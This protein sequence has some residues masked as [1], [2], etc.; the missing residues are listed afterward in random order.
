MIDPALPRFEA[1]WDTGTIAADL[2]A[3]LTLAPGWGVERVELDKIRH[4]MGER[5]IVQYRAIGTDGLARVEW[6]VTATAHADGKAA[7]VSVKSRRLGVHPPQGLGSA[8]GYHPALD[9]AFSAFPLD[10][11]L[12]AAVA[13]GTG[14]EFAGLGFEKMIPVR[15]RAGLGAT[16]RIPASRVPGGFLKLHPEGGAVASARRGS[17]VARVLPPS[18]GAAIP[19]LVPDL[20][21]ATITDQVAGESFDRCAD[22]EN[23]VLVAEALAALHQ[24]SAP[25]LPSCEKVPASRAERGAEWIRLVFPDATPALERAIDEAGRLTTGMALVHG[26]MKPDHLLIAG[27]AVTMV[28]LDSAGIGRPLSD[29]ASLVVR[30]AAP[31]IARSVLEAYAA[32]RPGMDWRGFDGELALAA[33]KFALYHAQHRRPGWEQAVLDTLEARLAFS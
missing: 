11:R 23:A 6:W 22:P 29:V 15:H 31:S 7:G 25:D 1:A 8:A 19:R 4:R 13:L 2:P 28:D 16:L 12:P 20:D 21:E 30:V 17:Q 24:V 3:V 32:A 10:R 33:V 18:V 5:G 26:D 27:P 14:A 9:M